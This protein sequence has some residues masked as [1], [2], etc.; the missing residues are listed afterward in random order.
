MT[1]FHHA[2]RV[3]SE[4]PS[5]LVPHDDAL[6]GLFAAL[7]RVHAI[8]RALTGSWQARHVKV[9]TWLVDDS[10]NIDHSRL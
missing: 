1:K 4:Q 5:T 10:C 8:M 9:F 2:A 7:G 6:R 3:L